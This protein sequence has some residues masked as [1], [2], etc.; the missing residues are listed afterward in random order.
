MSLFEKFLELWNQ[1]G[2][3]EMEQIT[4]HVLEFIRFKELAGLNEEVEKLRKQEAA[5]MIKSA[6]W[7]FFPGSNIRHP[8]RLS[9]P[10]LTFCGRKITR[11]CIIDLK[12][13]AFPHGQ[14]C[15]S[16][17]ESFEVIDYQ[18]WYAERSVDKTLLG[19]KNPLL[20]RP[21][22]VFPAFYRNLYGQEGT[23]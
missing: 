9:H 12:R 11:D 19:V 18:F 8:R 1:A 22:E 17:N 5:A 7:V 23:D 21:N 14:P 3:E 15:R 16:C 20:K 4:K 2:N 6:D 10:W 13:S